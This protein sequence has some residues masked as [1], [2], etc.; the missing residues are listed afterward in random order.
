[1]NTKRTDI[2]IHALACA[3]LFLFCAAGAKLSAQTPPARSLADALARPIVTVMDKADTSITGKHDYV[4]Y[5]RYYWP[6]QSKPGGLPYVLHDGD[7]NLAQIA[8][9]D[10]ERLQ[11]FFNT[12][13]T[14][15]N[16]WSAKRD[17]AAARRAVE[18]LRA[19]FISP[20][21]RMNPN[22]EHAQIR[23]GSD[24]NRGTPA[25]I[26]D[27]R[28]FGRVID[29]IKALDNSPALNAADKGAIRSWFDIYLDWLLVSKIGAAE[30]AARD[31]HV[32]WFVA[33]ALPI[34][35]YLGR[36]NLAQSLAEEIKKHMSRQIARDGSQPEEL[37]NVNS[38]SS[39]VF[40]LEG[41]ARV[42]KA[43]APLGVDLWNYVTAGRSSL[44]RAIDFLT[45]YNRDPSK[46]PFPQKARLQP[47]FLDALIK[48]RDAMVQ[49]DSEVGT[50][51]ALSPALQTPL[52]PPPAPTP[53]PAPAFASAPAP[54]STPPVPAPAPMP[55]QVQAPMSAPVPAQAFG[56]APAAIPQSLPESGPA[57][58]SALGFGP[59][60]A[61][62]PVSAPAA[63]PPPPVSVVPSFSATP[64]QSKA[65]TAVTYPVEP[66]IAVMTIV[67]QRDGSIIFNGQRASEEQVAQKLPQVRAASRVP[68]FI[69]MDENAPIKT[70]SFIMDACRKSGFNRISMQTQ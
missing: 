26:I 54:A 33:Q 15:A 25:G 37:R 39:S 5:A 6:D 19:W 28:D 2:I 29:S 46:W 24:N 9:G 22:L 68:V 23:L 35:T 45:P 59:V 21:T 8:L 36:E 61:P 51:P 56:S 67:I 3:A 18:W 12:V 30:R 43:A 58:A 52:P 69:S 62:P 50:M 34:A 13:E 53:M 57:P 65:D 31:S 14:L 49:P 27:T 66:D 48:E 42:A 38:L 44:S 20:A 41:Y 70:L 16:A 7:E 40:N 1:M 17:A 55:V 10:Y 11:T 60:S 4:S 63:Q 47:G 32:T 64:P